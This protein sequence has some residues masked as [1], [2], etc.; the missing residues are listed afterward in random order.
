MKRLRIVLA[1]FIHFSLEKAWPGMGTSSLGA[2]V[3]KYPYLNPVSLLVAGN[4]PSTCFLLSQPVLPG[5][6]QGILGAAKHLC[7]LD[8][9]YA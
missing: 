5:I 3:S 1:H 7:P 8:L 2:S 4:I 9:P 6:R